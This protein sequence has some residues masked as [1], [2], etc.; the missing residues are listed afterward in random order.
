MI[1]NPKIPRHPSDLPTDPTDPSHYLIRAAQGHSIKTV[2]NE[3]I[4][5]ALDHADPKCPKFVV[6]GTDESS[7]KKIQASGGLR[8]MNR[9]LIHFARGVPAR[10]KPLTGVDDR[11]RKEEEGVDGVISGMRLSATVLVW[12]D[13]RGSLEKGVKWW[14]SENNVFLTDGVDGLLGLEWIRWVEKRGTDELFW[15][16]KQGVDLNVGGEDKGRDIE[17]GMGGLKVDVRGAN[18]GSDVTE[19]EKEKETETARTRAQEKEKEK[20]DEV[21]VKKG[22]TVI[23]DSWD[24]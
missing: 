18:E 9:R 2:A 21:M 6:H 4:L 23:K 3:E 24:D 22:D 11:P 19:K 5:E 16:E 10:C 17:R 13:L 7:W 20:E 1:P 12:A 15:G 14:R 8:P